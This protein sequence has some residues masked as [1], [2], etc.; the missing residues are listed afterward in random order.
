[1]SPQKRRHG[2]FPKGDVRGIVGKRYPVLS[3][4]DVVFNP[5]K[6]KMVLINSLVT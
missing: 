6:M 2:G 5:F 4:G 3:E 1:M